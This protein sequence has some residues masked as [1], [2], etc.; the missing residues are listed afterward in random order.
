MVLGVDD[1]KSSPYKGQSRSPAHSKCVKLPKELFP[2]KQYGSSDGK[3]G[4]GKIY[5]MDAED[6]RMNR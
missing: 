6:P 2:E 5:S 3:I 1:V 4:R